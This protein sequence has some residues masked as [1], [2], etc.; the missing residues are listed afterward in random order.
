[1]EVVEIVPGSPAQKAGLR[2]E[3]L[4]VEVDG[5]RVQ[6]VIDLQRLMV[7]DV[8]EKAVELTVVRQGS[9]LKL[10]LTPAELPAHGR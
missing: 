8:I 6:G 9:L 5:A 4:I 2:A 7:A 3:D 10:E 1:V